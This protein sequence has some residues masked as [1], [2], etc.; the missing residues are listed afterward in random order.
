MQKAQKESMRH[1]ILFILACMGLASCNSFQA[2]P[3]PYPSS[4]D[5]LN[6]ALL[7]TF[8]GKTETVIGCSLDAEESTDAKTFRVHSPY[9]GE[10]QIY[11]CGIDRKIL[12]EEPG[13]VDFQLPNLLSLGKRGNCIL[14][15][16]YNFR[17]QDNF[18]RGLRGRIFIDRRGP[19]QSASIIS[20]HY[21]NTSVGVAAIKIREGFE[22]T[23]QEIHV[24]TSR[25]TA[26]GFYQIMGCG[27]GIK[28]R[29]FAGDGFD[30]DLSEVI[31]LPS[32]K[33]DCFL[34]GW[35]VDGQG[36]N[37]TLSLGLTVFTRDDIKI[38]AHAYIEKKRVCFVADQYVSLIVYGNQISSKLKGCFK[39]TD[40]SLISFYTVQGR[41]L[42]GSL[43][44]GDVQWKD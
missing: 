28:Q 25:P 40:S 10:I 2:R 5:T 14:D 43:E 7:I 9:Q 34:F 4:Y 31:Q 42:H 13:N 6:H 36:L 8:C 15:I 41:A 32:K 24:K 27:A 21:K 18:P 16:Q 30:F 12:T 29:E 35:A 3:D 11:G 26:R 33:S 37:D 19:G 38:G 39:L 20:D 23:I 1:V 44:G 22:S 17:V